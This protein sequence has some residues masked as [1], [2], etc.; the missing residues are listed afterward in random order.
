L[1]AV[2][3]EWLAAHQGQTP[4]DLSWSEMLL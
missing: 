2:A 4:Q 3:I 1:P